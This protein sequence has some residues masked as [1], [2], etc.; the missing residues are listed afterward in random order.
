MDLDIKTK[1]TRSLSLVSAAADGV[2][3]VF[4]EYSN[5]ATIH[6]VAQLNGPRIYNH[7]KLV[8]LILLFGMAMG[9]GVM[10]F[11]QFIRLSAWPTITDLQAKFSDN[12][13]FPAVT[14][15]NL[16]QFYK[17]RVPNSTI[18]RKL[19]FKLS[20]LETLIDLNTS[21]IDDDHDDDHDMP[22]D[23]VRDFALNAAHRLE[24]M[25]RICFWRSQE[26]NCSDVFSKTITTF[27]V[28][29][30]FN[31]NASNV[32]SC[33][34]PGPLG[35]L[36]VIVNI[37]QP[38]YSFS[39]T[40][41]SGIK[42][43]LHEPSEMTFPEVD[44]LWVGPGLSAYIAIKRSSK[45]LLP[46]PYKAF[47]SS[48]CL[49]TKSPSFTTPLI[50]F[51]D[52]NYTKLACVQECLTDILVQMCGCRIFFGPGNDT[53]CSAKE[54]MNCYIKARSNLTM[55]DF[56]NCSCPE[57][58]HQVHYTPTFS[59]ANFASDFIAYQ[60]VK[61]NFMNSTDYLSRNSIELRIFYESL[62]NTRIVQRPEV[63]YLDILGTLG[64]HMGL[65][66]GASLLSLSEIIEMC[67][68]VIARIISKIRHCNRVPRVM[69][70]KTMSSTD[71][72]KK[73]LSN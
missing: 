31:G 47:G 54:T 19:I 13:D 23:D 30:T 73:N 64:G 42:V 20:Q 36:R 63:T 8:W 44:G 25:L 67:I 43:L 65:F 52:Y 66:L 7:R 49:N 39:K 5:H 17:D 34:N 53:I 56:E 18:I 37:Q 61:E 28:C 48:V 32:R 12:L 58:C 15:C 24:E 16:N 70:E 35:G 10:M 38:Q 45:T 62:L 41:Q 6:G 26:V 55:T 71:D 22:G 46:P 72:V 69:S 27:G 4:A 9:L 50:R 40:F 33:G 14:I 57:P 59:H 68:V 2:K 51:H 21:N 1:S 3:D 60:L 29:Y 11:Q